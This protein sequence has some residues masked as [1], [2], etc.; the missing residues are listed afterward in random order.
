MKI[1]SDSE[2]S[3]AVEGEDVPSHVRALRKVGDDAPART[4]GLELR[5]SLVR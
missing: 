2:P 4:S 3:R 5:A 1:S